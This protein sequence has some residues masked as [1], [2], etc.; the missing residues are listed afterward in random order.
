M[1]SINGMSSKKSD[2][3]YNESKSTIEPIEPFEII[4][5]EAF[6]LA[7]TLRVFFFR[8]IFILSLFLV[9]IILVWYT[10]T[11]SQRAQTNLFIQEAL[12]G[13]IDFTILQ[14]TKLQALG[15][16]EWPWNIK[17]NKISE[18]II[19]VPQPKYP[20]S[21]K[22]KSH[23]SSGKYQNLYSCRSKPKHLDN[24]LRIYQWKDTEGQQHMSDSFPKSNDYHDLVVQNLDSENFFTLKLDKKY[25]RLPA[26]A[27]DRMKRD[28][29]QI[30]KILTKNVGVSQLNHITLNL[31]LFDDKGRFN[32]Y[33]KKVAPGMG[34]AGGFYIS[35]LNEASVFTSNDD[36]RMYDVTR[37]EATHAIV[38]GALG[39]APIW[40]NEGLA[41]YFEDLTFKNGMTRIV[42]PDESHL[43]LLSKTSLPGLKNHFSM[44]SEQWY[45][46]PGK[47]KN[48]ALGWSLVYFLMSSDR[49]RQFLKYMLDHLAY[50]YCKPFSEIAYINK[51]YPG[52]LSG[53]EKNWKKWLSR[54][55]REH[56][57]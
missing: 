35:R 39:S 36:Q 52:G 55:K 22:V 9:S 19:K 6:S 42:K 49:D 48:Y 46:E 37:H 38:A 12:K 11:E 5:T 14:N 41:E 56:R 44:S 3:S 29:N 15:Y 2:I 8:F 33:K 54:S 20:R 47:T 25:S 34:T 16:F 57:Y 30:Y 53:F 4:D 24:I 1:E 50:N 17:E 18:E 40:L 7:Q 45:D 43:K 13:N 21:I 51:Y 32:T 31:K 23:F 26:F 28:V 10:S 27:S